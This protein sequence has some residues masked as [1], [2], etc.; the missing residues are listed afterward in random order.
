[1]IHMN[2]TVIICTYNRSDSLRRTLESLSRQKVP[3]GFEF[4]VIVVDNNSNDSTKQVVEHAQNRLNIPCLR[5]EFEKAQGL[6]FAR[7]RGIACA[8]GDIVLFTDDDVTVAE[9]WIYEIIKGMEQYDCQAC[10]GYIGPVWETQP[11]YWL[12]EI[13]YGFLAVRT[14]EGAPKKV[15]QISDL[16]FGA[17]MAIRKDVFEKVGTFNTSLG[18]K[19]NVLSSYDDTDLLDRIIQSGGYIYY[20]PHARVYHH[21]ESYRTT[22]KYF[23]R[24]RM[25]CSRNLAES[26]G[27]PGYRK[28]FGVPVYIY[29]QLIRSV[30]SAARDRFVLQPDAAFRKELIVWH[31][32]GLI[33]GLYNKRSEQ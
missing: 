30:I 24:W 9:D 18:R 14:D 7:N 4:E 11:P 23:R 19:G 27:I 10:G 33:A 17:N 1:M 13:F 26:H 2:A 28:L 6:C 12:T 21:I 31:F 22:K 16:P 5:Y 3:E 29:S 32:I 15:S 20:L 25:H 8:R